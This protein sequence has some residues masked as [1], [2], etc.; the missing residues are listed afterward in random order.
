M[1]SSLLISPNVASTLLE[2]TQT[3]ITAA[4]IVALA[5][6]NWDYIRILQLRRKLP[7]GPFPWPIVGNH[8]QIPRSRPWVEWEKWAQYYGSPLTT[9]WVGREPR[10]LV[11]DAWADSELMEKNAHIFSTRPKL[12]M[13]GEVIG[14]SKT[15]QTMPAAWA[16]VA[17]A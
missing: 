1:V 7:P 5:A 2:A 17:D 10:I 12:F 8:F 13:M 3:T 6:L 4:V 14:M 16:S 9:I 11:Q 15:N